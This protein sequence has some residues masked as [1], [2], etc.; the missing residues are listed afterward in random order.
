MSG[1]HSKQTHSYTDTHTHKQLSKES[2]TL[3]LNSV[4]V[5]TSARLY[6]EGL[7][8]TKK[9]VMVQ[10]AAGALPPPG[11]RGRDLGRP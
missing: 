11:V 10:D 8:N 4:S 7:L 1:K 3:R 9:V 5:K 2:N 6:E